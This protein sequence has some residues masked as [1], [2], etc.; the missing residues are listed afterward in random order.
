MIKLLL[1][2]VSSL[3]LTSCSTFQT[4]AKSTPN[5]TNTSNYNE[6]NIS[7]I[8]IS[9]EDS[10]LNAL[11]FTQ[12]FGSIRASECSG[13]M[14]DEQCLE[15][16]GEQFAIPDDLSLV[17]KGPQE[18]GYNY[19]EL[20]NK[21]DG[22]TL[23]FGILS[24]IYDSEISSFNFSILDGKSCFQI[25]FYY[26]ENN[27]NSHTDRYDIAYRNKNFG[28]PLFFH[29]AYSITQDQN[30]I[31]NKEILGYQEDYALVKEQ[32][33]YLTDESSIQDKEACKYYENLEIVKFI[34]Q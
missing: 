34:D 23:K 16:Y 15:M 4:P 3:V 10:E 20:S 14:S 25:F 22:T 18:D 2:I 19:F 9:Y 6:N 13:D 1:V 33:F 7:T 30:L 31:S 8:S 11:D 28:G 5:E 29:T 12:F 32:Q 27:I 21:L 26:D 17:D 24:A